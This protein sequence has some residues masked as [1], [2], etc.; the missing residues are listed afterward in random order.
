M[1]MQENID[2]NFWLTRALAKRLGVNLTEAMHHGFLTQQDFA[3][4]ITDCRRCA[5]HDGCLRFLAE[6]DGALEEPPAFCHNAQIL[7][8]LAALV[9]RH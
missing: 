9:R 8:E 2:L 6:M 4:M 5:E 7:R 1:G 3:G